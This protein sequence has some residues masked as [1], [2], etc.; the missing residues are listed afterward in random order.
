MTWSSRLKRSLKNSSLENEDF[1]VR[2]WVDHRLYSCFWILHRSCCCCS[3]EQN[4]P[5]VFLTVVGVV[6]AKYLGF[7]WTPSFFFD[8]IIVV[9][10]SGL[11]FQ[12]LLG[13]FCGGGEGDFATYSVAYG[14]WWWRIPRQREQSLRRRRT[15]SWVDGLFS[16]VSMMMLLSFL[17]KRPIVTS[18]PNHVMQFFSTDLEC[19][20]II[21][22]Y[23]LISQFCSGLIQII[24]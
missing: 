2:I 12:F 4:R 18:L 15:R 23:F 24:P 17:R 14:H 10:R 20:A 21:L 19:V 7:A 3:G 5:K 22:I 6:D 1:R 13:G 8:A 11:G 16:V 9:K